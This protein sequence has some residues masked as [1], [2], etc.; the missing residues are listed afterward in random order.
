MPHGLV[1]R[2]APNREPLRQRA[3]LETTRGKD[4]AAQR[5]AARPMFEELAAAG[6]R[7]GSLNDLVPSIAPRREYIKA[8][9]I[10]LRWLER[11]ENDDLRRALVRILSSQ[12]AAPAAVQPLL[13]LY[14]SERGARGRW[15]IGNAL[16]VMADDSVFE[17]IRA[18][19][20]T[21]SYGRDREMLV[22]A[23]PAMTTPPARDLMIECLDDEDLTAHALVAIRHARLAAARGSVERFVDDPRMLVRREARKALRALGAR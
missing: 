14:R 13:R 2:P 7:F 22:L 3:V 9:P 21:R 18:L 10:V 17:E 5:Q 12:F 23:L 20:R 19:L 1:T 11:T 16:S 4:V 8:V 15:E 6:L